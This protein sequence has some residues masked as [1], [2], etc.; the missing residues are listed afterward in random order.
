MVVVVGEANV[1]DGRG[2]RVRVSLVIAPTVAEPG[3]AQVS[4]QGPW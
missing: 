3:P 2:A 4:P 1:D